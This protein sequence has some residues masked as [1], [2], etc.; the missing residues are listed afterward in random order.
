GH[1]YTHGI[2]Y[3]AHIDPLY[4]FGQAAAL[5][6]SFADIFGEMV[7]GWVEGSID[8]IHGGDKTAGGFRDMSDPNNSSTEK[9]DTYFG[10]YWDEDGEEHQN[11]TVQ[12]FMFYLLSE[13]G[14]GTNDHGIQYNV[15]GIGNE[16][17]EE[18]GWHAM[19]NYLNND[20]GYV[21]ARNAWIQSA[22]DLY[23]SCSQE[24]ISVGHA[25]Q[26]VG[27]TEY[28]IFDNTSFC[29]TYST[30]GYAD[31]TY[32]IENANLSFGDFSS[33]CATTI[34]SPAVVTLESGFYVQ[35][36]PGFEAK[37]GSTFVAWIDE[38]EISDYDS[39]DLKY[40]ETNND[41]V[42]ITNEIISAINLYPVPADQSVSVS[43][44]LSEQSTISIS[45]MDISGRE[46]KMWKQNQLAEKGN[47]TFEFST[48]D[49]ISGVYICVI[50]INGEIHINKFIVQH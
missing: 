49:F 33:N 17:A 6:E 27:V 40:A 5:N 50:K 3:Y 13:G 4:S 1:E 19:M 2:V 12:T 14:S 9:P 48:V 42:T 32:G 47:N 38:C 25:W 8:W 7:E 15:E 21:T 44:E 31:A 26:A 37:S 23:G 28:T 10:D 22:I 43:F 29:G 16:V 45:V 20:D 30:T 11:S 24:V 46:I 35:L 41:E 39:G 34:N 18:I 36:N